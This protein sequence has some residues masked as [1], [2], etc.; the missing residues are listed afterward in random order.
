VPGWNGDMAHV[1]PLGV[2]NYVEAC[3]PSTSPTLVYTVQKRQHGQWGFSTSMGHVGNRRATLADT[4]VLP[5][6]MGEVN[7][8][9]V[10]VAVTQSCQ[11]PTT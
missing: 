3:L 7:G 11:A 5:V 9:G 2:A 8:L 4:E 1:E 10:P 6:C